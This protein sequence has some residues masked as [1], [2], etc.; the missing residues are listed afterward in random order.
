MAR[1]IPEGLLLYMY[2]T[3]VRI[4]SCQ[5]KIVQD[6]AKISSVFGDI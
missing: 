6:G 3:L 5:S 4:K 1:R 2:I